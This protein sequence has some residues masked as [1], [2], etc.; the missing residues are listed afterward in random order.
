MIKSWKRVRSGSSR[1][2]RVFSIRTDTTLSPRTGS[3][4][5]FYVIESRDWIN[6]IPLTDDHQV[7]MI[8]QY[9][10]GSREVTLEIPGGLVDPGEPPEKAAAR[11][12]LEETG[13]RAK[14]W[15]KIGVVNPN[16]ALFNNRCH[17]FLAR[18]IN[19]VTNPMPD[20]T[21]DIEVVLVPLTKIPRLI[22]KGE[23]DHAMVITAF[24]HYFLR[25]PERLGKP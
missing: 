22:L 14:K 11:E 6:V 12:L 24:T 19:R 20:Q 25:N 1:S 21:E 15:L 9:R 4:H 13:Y 17:T 18:N 16:P 8:R 3:K 5:N 10:H 23:I 2:F 7:V